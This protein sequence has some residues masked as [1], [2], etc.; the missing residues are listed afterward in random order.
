VVAAWEGAL[1][2]ARLAGSTQSLKMFFDSHTRAGAQFGHTNESVIRSRKVAQDAPG[3]G[4]ASDPRKVTRR[5]P[6]GPW[7][8]T[9][10]PRIQI[11]MS[12]AP[13]LLGVG[14]VALAQLKAEIGRTQAVQLD[15]KNRSI[16]WTIRG[17]RGTS[18]NC[19]CPA[20][21]I[22]PPCQGEG[23]EC[24]LAFGCKPSDRGR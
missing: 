6:E 10:I 7:D 14:G 4:V 20:R 16:W 3:D 24:Y 15:D 12:G 17:Q 8:P 1:W 9:K 22:K 21:R 5:L 13:S 19:V 2:R 11:S 18:E 23:R